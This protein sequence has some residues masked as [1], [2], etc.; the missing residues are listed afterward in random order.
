MVFLFFNV[1]DLPL[2]YFGTGRK[3][4]LIRLIV[5]DVDGTLLPDSAREIPSLLFSEISRLMK[6]GI[7]FCPASGRQYHSLRRLFAPLA[8]EIP[9]VCENG[10]VIFGPG[11]PGPI[12][13]KSIMDRSAVLELSH[14]ILN[15]PELEIVL[16]GTNTSY[17]CPKQANMISY[18]RDQ[19]GNRVE[20]LP[21]PEAIPE[22]IVKVSAYCPV[23]AVT[24][25]QQLTAPWIGRFHAA[26]SGDNWLDFTNASK[27]SGLRTLCTMWGITR[28]EVM[29][30]GDNYNDV[31]ML[32][33]AGS[34]YLMDSAHSELK[35]RFSNR[36]SRVVDILATL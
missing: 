35:A 4:Y 25:E 1:F 13:E 29:A 24:V 34:P 2:H 8:D 22:D 28:D 10:A 30:F 7:L 17:L 3:I 33:W 23:G 6:K 18:I 15:T 20:V 16:S 21:S 36:C 11:C 12:L 32:E 14:E 26:I 27:G 19:L 31:S 9:Y 5:S